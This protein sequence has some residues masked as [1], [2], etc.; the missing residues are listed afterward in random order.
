M[1]ATDAGA[2]CEFG[3]TGPAADAHDADLGFGVR[4]TQCATDAHDAGLCG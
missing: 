2:V 1:S 3:R 4:V